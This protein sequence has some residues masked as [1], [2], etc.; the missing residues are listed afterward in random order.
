MSRSKPLPVTVWQLVGPIWPHR[1]LSDPIAHRKQA[2]H[3]R[4]RSPSS[5]PPAS[6]SYWGRFVCAVLSLPWRVMPCVGIEACLFVYS[7]ACQPCGV[8]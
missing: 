1:A 8:S 6:W 7:D 2:V 5:S 4:R 3:S